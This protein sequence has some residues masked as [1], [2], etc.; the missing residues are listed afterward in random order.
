MNGSRG[1]AGAGAAKHESWTGVC[2]GWA[3]GPLEKGTAVIPV[4]SAPHQSTSR[5]GALPNRVFYSV[6]VGE[7]GRAVRHRCIGARFG[8]GGALRG[9]R[10]ASSNRPHAGRRYRRTRE[11]AESKGGRYRR[12]REIAL[13]LQG[14]DI[15]QLVKS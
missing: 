10:E 15:A 13:T 5:V 7:W 8:A 4:P 12:I 11:I 6:R 1:W 2:V 14:V 3:R 9:A